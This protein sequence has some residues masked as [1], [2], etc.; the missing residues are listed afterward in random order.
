MGYTTDFTGRF[1]LDKALTPEHAAYLAAFAGT[2]RMARTASKTAQREDPVRVAAKLG[3]GPGGGYFVGEGGFRGQGEDLSASWEDVTNSNGPPSGQPGLWC[4]WV[5]T[6][7][8]L[9]IEWDG[10]E[11]FYG[12]QEWLTYLIEHFLKPW[13]YVL[14]GSVGYSGEEPGDVGCVVCEDN[15]VS[16]QS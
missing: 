6:E 7:D 10:G 12:Y 1:N 9:G 14:N 15:R 4:Q 2:R 13:G 16:L 3:V 11:K 5:P 8:L